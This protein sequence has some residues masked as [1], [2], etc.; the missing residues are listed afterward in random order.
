MPSQPRSYR[1]FASAGTPG[2]WVLA[3]DRLSR[4][5][6]E[7]VLDEPLVVVTGLVLGA[8]ERVWRNRERLEFGAYVRPSEALFESE[9]NARAARR[10]IPPVTHD[11]GRD[12]A[13]LVNFA[14]GSALR[15]NEHA[16][17]SGCGYDA[18]PPCDN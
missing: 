18:A 12:R 6:D 16:A 1:V 8:L 9:R 4:D 17:C 13:L 15:L 7:Q 5:Q 2:T 14:C 10:P 11:L 3:Y